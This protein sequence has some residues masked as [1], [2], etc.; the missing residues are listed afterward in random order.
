M[1]KVELHRRHLVGSSAARSR[2]NDDSVGATF[3]HKILGG[4]EGLLMSGTRGGL[5]F[6]ARLF[7]ASTGDFFNYLAL[8]LYV[9]PWAGTT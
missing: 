6:F 4:F 7:P 5:P 9:A 8:V 3:C 2:H 1:R